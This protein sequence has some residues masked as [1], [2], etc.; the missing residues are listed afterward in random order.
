MNKREKIISK[1]REDDL[2]LERLLTEYAVKQ[3]SIRR[4]ISLFKVFTTRG[5]IVLFTRKGVLSQN[6]RQRLSINI[7]A[8]F[9]GPFYFFYRKLYLWGT[10]FLIASALIT[11]LSVKLGIKSIYLLNLAVTLVVFLHAN[12]IYLRKFCDSLL[13]AGYGEADEQYVLG[14]L[15]ASGGVNIWALWGGAAYLI[16]FMTMLI[17]LFSGYFSKIPAG[18]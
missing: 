10:L 14:Y 16:S 2:A 11:Y 8:F 7:G 9:L 5:D 18:V 17:M 3:R 12:A 15:K 6:P 1:L 13:E 4:Y